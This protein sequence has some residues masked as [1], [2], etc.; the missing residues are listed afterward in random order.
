M[1]ALPS[2]PQ[3]FARCCRLSC[4]TD[5]KRVF[6]CHQGPRVR[7]GCFTIYSCPN[8]TAAR[9]GI[10]VSRKA[11]PRAVTRN[12]IKR[13]VRESFRCCRMQL[14]P[15]DFVVVC[16]ASIAYVS[17]SK[18]AQGLHASWPTAVHQHQQRQACSSLHT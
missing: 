10:V 12:R 13:F 15:A 16:H 4:S 1:L 11:V 6:R 5:F 7:R 9:L 17:R 8:N 3:G 18:L 14:P 2:K